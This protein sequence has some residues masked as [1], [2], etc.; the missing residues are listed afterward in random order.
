M[1][2]LQ[3]LGVSKGFSKRK[4]ESSVY[5][6]DSLLQEDT[7]TLVDSVQDKLSDSSLSSRVSHVAKDELSLENDRLQEAF[8]K[9]CVLASRQE[10]SADSLLRK[11][12]AKG[13]S[14]EEAEV[15]VKRAQDYGFVNDER[16][17]E[18]LIRSRINQGKGSDAIRRE[19]DKLNL[20]HAEELLEELLP[21]SNEE[22]QRAL[23]F[24]RKHPPHSKNPLQSAYRKLL[25][26]GYSSEVA[27]RAARSFL[28]SRAADTEMHW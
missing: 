14:S 4:E 9:A 20:Q 17:A 21:D 13:Y 24:L 27:S 1:E 12:L 28:D 2:A 25:T 3:A 7:L 16:Y 11:L 26:K 23:E 19:I 5:S 22:F 10:H 6:A 18:L 15:A 8:E